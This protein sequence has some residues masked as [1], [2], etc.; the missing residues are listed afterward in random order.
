[1]S[2][3]TLVVLLLLIALAALL[4]VGYAEHQ[5][6]R[7]MALQRQLQ[8][9]RRRIFDLEEILL[10]V[11]PVVES[12]AIPLLVNE[13]QLD[14]IYAALQ[15]DPDSETLIAHRER[16]EQRAQE[17]EEFD[18][19]RSVNRLL[20]SDSSIAYAQ[21]NINEAMRVLRSQHA[22]GNL[23]I[24]ELDL[25]LNELTWAQV[26]VH[27]ISMVAQGHKAITRG[28][29]LSALAYYR[30][31]QQKLIDTMHSDERRLTM[32]SQ[33]T[34]LLSGTRAALSVDLMPETT[35]NPDIDSPQAQ[36]MASPA[37]AGNP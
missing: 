2:A 29:R 16:N 28:N 23:E 19:P 22:K 9:L 10:A 33:L 12:L 18:R 24:A 36:P 25:F 1:M 30:K 27:V 15:L 8:Q 13:E 17:L 31:A 20:D 11:E 37:Q 32:I 6:A 7:A 35:Y 14:V 34:E 4:V 5:H 26:M 3:S 21:Y